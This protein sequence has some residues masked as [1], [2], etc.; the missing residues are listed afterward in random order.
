MP[1]FVIYD[2]EQCG[3]LPYQMHNYTDTAFTRASQ[4]AYAPRPH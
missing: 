2:F 4:Y 1:H 3:Q